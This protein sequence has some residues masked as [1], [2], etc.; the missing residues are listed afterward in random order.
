VNNGYQ[1]ETTGKA[2]IAVAK[3]QVEGAVAV[4]RLYNRFNGA[5]YYTVNDTERDILVGFGWTY[6]K[7]EG[8]LFAT[9][10]LNAREIFRLYNKNSGHHLFT[11]SATTK[12]SE[13]GLG[14]SICRDADR[15]CDASG[16]K[17]WGRV[18]FD[19]RSE[20]FDRRSGACDFSSLKS[21]ARQRHR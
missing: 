8:F 18:G 19:R 3:T 14:V 17:H 10:T 4:H 7:D 20:I 21:F 16:A 2:T 13:L 15:V 6:E 5:H 1:D 9:P 11:D 12:D